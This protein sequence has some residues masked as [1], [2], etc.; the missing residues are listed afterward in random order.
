MDVFQGSSLLAPQG[1]WGRLGGGLTEVQPLPGELPLAGIIGQVFTLLLQ[2]HLP[3][4]HD[5]GQVAGLDVCVGWLEVGVE[6]AHWVGRA[7]VA[8]VKFCPGQMGSPQGSQS[9]R[10]QWDK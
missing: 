1:G 2:R 5:N 7:A 3:G 10:G 9:G 8:W 4:V 6:T